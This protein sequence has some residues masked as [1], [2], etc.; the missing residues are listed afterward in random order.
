MPNKKKSIAIATVFYGGNTLDFFIRYLVAIKKLIKRSDPS[1]KVSVFL[2]DN[3][4][5]PFLSDY[6]NKNKV[7]LPQ[8]VSIFENSSK[9]G[10][11]TGNNY[12]A[13]EKIPKSFE[14]ILFLNPDTEVDK[15][16]LI[17]MIKPFKDRKVFSADA[18]QYPFEHPKLYDKKTNQVSW[19][20]GAC[21]LTRADIYRKL[22]GFDEKFFMYAEDVDLSWKAWSKGYKCVYTPKARCIHTCYGYSKGAL[23]RQYWMIKNGFLMRYRWGKLF[24]Y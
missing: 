22:G 1:L 7:V 23:F 18:N 13:F 20:S 24:R 19:C 21:L 3:S 14:Y 6:I 11:A 12:L 8:Q 9:N 17:E 16:L 15:N 10:F 2:L 5:K 4:P